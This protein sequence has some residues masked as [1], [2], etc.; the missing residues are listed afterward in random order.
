MKKTACLLFLGL[1][2]LC[3][4]VHA[5]NLLKNASYEDVGP[6]PDTA[7]NWYRWGDWVNREESWSPTHG[8]TCLIGYHHWQ[9]TSDANSGL[10]QDVTTVKAGQKFKFSVFV[11]A[12]APDNGAEPAASVELRLE[13]I[14][15]GKELQIESAKTNVS[16]LIKSAGWHELSVSGT[17]PENN[18]R[19]LVVV[20]PAPGGKRG[21]AI[22]I[23]DAKL[24][25]AK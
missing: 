16:D 20:T 23:D 25:L 12:D 3:G 11:A 6:S 13:A 9:I 22:K 19:V 7:A 18:V 21:G 1:A 14:R 4:T 8:G 24:E 17:T 15:G 5:Q 2:S 10:W